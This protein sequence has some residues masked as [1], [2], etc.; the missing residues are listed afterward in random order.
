MLISNENSELGPDQYSDILNDYGEIFATKFEPHAQKYFER[1][2]DK[3]NLLT[4]LLGE[5]L[6]DYNK[7]FEK[8][9]LHIDI[10]DFKQEYNLLM[11]NQ[12]VKNNI[13]NINEYI[14]EFAKYRSTPT[15]KNIVSSS[16]KKSLSVI[17]GAGSELHQIMISDAEY[18][19][20]IYR[21][22]KKNVIVS[23]DQETEGAFSGIFNMTKNNGINALEPI[24]NLRLKQMFDYNPEYK[25][26]IILGEREEKIMTCTL[27]I[28]N[29]I[30][31]EKF[32]IIII[33]LKMDYNAISRCY[34]SHLFAERKIDTKVFV[35]AIRH[36]ICTSIFFSDEYNIKNFDIYMYT[37][38]KYDKKTNM[39][40]KLSNLVATKIVFIKDY[41]SSTPATKLDLLNSSNLGNSLFCKTP[42]ISCDI[43]NLTAREPV[44]TGGLT[45]DMINVYV[46]NKKKYMTLRNA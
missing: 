5:L 26:N 32:S 29:D 11:L 42:D 41:I 17:V 7:T 45:G 15:V 39:R 14:T 2:T 13:V 21:K 36:E 31:N 44:L 9:G 46:S 23:F 12:Q 25:W 33:F 1:G 37:H 4:T 3:I 20:T 27:D 38:S 18:I 10:V 6:T 19:D 24:M 22:H 16:E 40:G 35:C 30:S 8:Y 43:S 28:Y 34:I